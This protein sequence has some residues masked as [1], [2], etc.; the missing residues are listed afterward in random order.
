M[1]P[2]PGVLAAILDSIWKGWERVRLTSGSRAAAAL[3]YQECLCHVLAQVSRMAPRDLGV[4][5][6]TS[7]VHA[8]LLRTPLVHRLDSPIAV[9][10]ARHLG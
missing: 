4:S 3:S 8:K 10:L 6:S 7:K 9:E 2:Q 1:G 5:P